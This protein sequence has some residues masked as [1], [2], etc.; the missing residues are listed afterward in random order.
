M[1]KGI[2]IGGMLVVGTILYAITNSSKANTIELQP[3]TD[4][5]ARGVRNNNWGNIRISNSNWLGK[6]GNDGSFEKFKSHEY[7][8]RALYVLL[9]N[10][11]TGNVWENKKFDTISKIVP[12]Y[13]PKSDGND[14]SR[15]IDFLSDFVGID[16]NKTID[17][18][19]DNLMYLLVAGICKIE[20]GKVPERDMFN[21]SIALK[22]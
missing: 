13:A 9:K 20:S 16:E 1:K 14:E 17:P 3:I 21:K 2:V 8:I 22:I 11:I 4:N 19:N 12:K 6:I 7:G 5:R 10:Y 15:Y 18:N